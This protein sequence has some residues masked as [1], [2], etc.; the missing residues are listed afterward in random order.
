M[1]KYILTILLIQLNLTVVFGQEKFEVYKEEKGSS[2]SIYL[3]SFERSYFDYF[4]NRVDSMRVLLGKNDVYKKVLT[5]DSIG[6]SGSFKI[7]FNE[8]LLF[9][10]TIKDGLVKGE[11][12]SYNYLTSQQVFWGRFEN[13][14][15]NGSLIRFSNYCEIEYVANYKKGE[16]KGYSYHSREEEF[17]SLKH[18][19]KELRPP[20]WKGIIEI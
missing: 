15:I 2:D 12:K 14:V 17:K 13:N 10:Y 20:F 16:F 11:G 7:Y 3:I 9:D 6:G 8:V 18:L 19:N 4:E 5:V 1:K